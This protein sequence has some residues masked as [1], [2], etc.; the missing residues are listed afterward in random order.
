MGWP[1]IR[2]FDDVLTAARA[3]DEASFAILWR[4][5]QPPLLR[6]LGVVA[7]EAVDEIA[8]DVWLSVV[9][10]LD[11]FEGSDRQFQGW[12]FT[13]AR[14]RTIDW[15]R[16]KRRQLAT[17]PLDGVDVPGAAD[18][19]ASVLA[20]ADVRAAIALLRTLRPDQAEVVGLRVIVGL[21]VAETARVVDKSENAVRVLCHRGL[22]TLGRRL[23]ARIEAGVT[24]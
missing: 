1:D 8:S 15:A 5:L 20:L 7:P 23:Q 11:E 21:S 10:A 12:I 3:G 6:W 16:R 22:Q 19:T 2:A 14:R 9:R 13:L 4:W 18:A 17:R 24:P